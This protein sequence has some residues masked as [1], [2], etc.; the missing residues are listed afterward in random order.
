MCRLIGF[1]VDKPLEKERLDKL[2]KTSRDLLKDQKDGF[3]YALSGGDIEG[4]TSLR[5]VT[6]NLLGYGYDPLGEWESVAKPTFDLRGEIKPCTAGLFHGRTSTNDLGIK[7]THPFVSDELALAHNG[8]VDYTGPRRKKVGTCDSEDLFNTFTKGKGW[9]ELSKYYEGY[10]AL[11]IIRRDGHLTIYRDETPSLYCVRFNGG[12]VVATSALDGTSVVKDV[13]EQTPQAPIQIKA[14]HAI[15]TKLGSILGK[16][17]V[18]PIRKRSYAKD[19]LSLGY[20][21]TYYPKK[22]YK[23]TTTGGWNDEDGTE[24]G[25]P[26]H[27]GSGSETDYQTGYDEGY[28]DNQNGAGYYEDKTQSKQF[29]KGYQEGYLQAEKD[30]TT[31]GVETEDEEAEETAEVIAV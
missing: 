7:N 19:Q 18:K 28:M 6:G 27:E 11:L 29:R 2:I 10:A 5:L 3:G 12:F 16:K 17:R 14:N 8:I 30:L 21:T 9:K 26:D 4:I 23:S 15:E 25:V 13:F 24:T 22:T 1:S 20:G 31:S